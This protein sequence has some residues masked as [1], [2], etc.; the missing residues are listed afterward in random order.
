MP[1]W[2]VTETFKCFPA[3]LHVIRSR[4][5]IEQY[6]PG[7]DFRHKGYLFKLSG[8]SVPEFI[9]DLKKSWEKFENMYPEL[10]NESGVKLSGFGGITIFINSMGSGISIINNHDRIK[11]RDTVDEYI[12]DLMAAPNRAALIQSRLEGIEK[13]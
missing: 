13:L 3:T 12:K 7:P 1:E 8:D 2:K 10:K 5:W 9:E 11:D 4:W 6:Y